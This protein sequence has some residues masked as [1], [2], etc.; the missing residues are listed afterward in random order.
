[1]MSPGIPVEIAFTLTLDLD[2]T[3]VCETR[4]W[5]PFVPGLNPGRVGPNSRKVR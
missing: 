1:M 5:K 2:G 3:K 4:P